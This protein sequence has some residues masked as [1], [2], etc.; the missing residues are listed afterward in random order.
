MSKVAIF[1][2]FTLLITGIICLLSTVIQLDN[3]GSLLRGALDSWYTS[4]LTLARTSR[5]RADYLNPNLT[6]E[7]CKIKFKWGEMCPKLYTELG[8]KC[9]LVD[10]T[11]QC[12]DI[13][14]YSK[15]R[16][17]QAQLVL[18][19]M[20]RIF[21]ILAQKHGI[22]YWI[23]RGTLLGAARHH[24]FIPWDGDGDI[25]MP[26]GDYVKFFQVAAKELPADMF[27]QNSVSDRALRP[28]D[29]S[30]YHRHEVV[31]IYQATFN[32]RLRDRNSC[33]KYCMTYNCKWHDGLMVDIFVTPNVD[34]AIYPLRRM[35]FEGFPLN[36]QNNWRKYL[37]SVYGEKWFEYP[38]NR[39]PEE[40][41]DVFNSCEKLMKRK[42]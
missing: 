7:H 14:N 3:S 38:T 17:R 5:R 25:E 12:P 30:G 33:Y 36:V 8:G 15:F 32:P 6:Y 40:N 13:R 20:L 37:V 24:G 11:F 23:S 18:T 29:I 19:R 1:L 21:D 10:D 35:T 4:N 16:P 28:S 27:F 31:F 39:P 9:D 42:Q 2:L 26:L 34:N 22:K 41:P